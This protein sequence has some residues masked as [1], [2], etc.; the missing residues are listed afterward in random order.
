MEWGIVLGEQTDDF[1]LRILNMDLLSGY[2]E[3]SRDSALYK[4]QISEDGFVNV[5]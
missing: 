1:P 3:A 5:V 2:W 4:L